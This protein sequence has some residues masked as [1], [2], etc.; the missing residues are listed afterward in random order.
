MTMIVL[1]TLAGVLSWS[2]GTTQLN[3]RANQYN[4]VLAAADGNTEAVLA[5]ITR[6]FNLGGAKMLA[7]N[8]NAYP[9]IVLASTGSWAGLEFND[10]QGNKNKTYVKMG[11]FD[12]YEVLNSSYEGLRGYVCP[13][14]IVSNARFN[15]RLLN[16]VAAVG[17][18]VQLANIPIFQFAMFSSAD[19]EISCGQPFQITGKVHSNKDL[20][21][22]PDNEMTFQS[23]VTV[24]G[25]SYFK[26]H[27]L[28][29]RPVPSGSVKYILPLQP[30]IHVKSLNL[31]IGAD[32]TPEAIREIIEPPDPGEDVNSPIARERYYNKCDLIITVTA[33]GTITATNGVPFG[34]SKDVKWNKLNT[35]VTTNTVF[36]DTREGKI[37]RP[38]DINIGNL[39]TWNDK[40]YFGGRDVMSVYIDDKR[41]LPAGEL[42]AVRLVNGLILPPNGLT[43]A[44]ARP[45]YVLGNY[46]Q[47]KISN[48]GTSNTTT[49]VPAS[50]VADAITI[51]S[52]NWQD[53]ASASAV[54][55]R[56]ASSTTVNAA[57][58]TGVVETVQ[59]SYSGGMENFPRFLETWGLANVF[60]YNGSMVKMFPSQY[61]IGRW[62]KGN[63][64]VPPKRNWAYDLN[65]NEANK[66][67]PLTPCV[68]KVIRA[69]WTSLAPNQTTISTPSL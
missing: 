7:D 14:E 66:L 50:L 42:A 62:G 5:K 21:I 67:P 46:N 65:F 18:S 11:T 47:N 23:D 36:T 27:P 33:S 1:A 56:V 25:E 40:S 48:L 54:N 8:K 59:D 45:L 6:D 61:A 4:Q 9:N 13:V 37:V 10:A 44:T 55:L 3:E 63:V 69:Q 19:M 51:L 20:Y 31:P 68:Q 52:G 15:N 58:L 64:Y 38:I 39:R 16:V 49:T 22:E 34:Q 12:N 2:A 28:D 53:L 43:V 30:Q 32:N 35:F 17:Q 29:T 41:V 26:R 24:V 60:T 57:L